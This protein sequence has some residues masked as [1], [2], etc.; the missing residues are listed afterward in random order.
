MAIK[1]PACFSL[2]W[3]SFAL[4]E[5]EYKLPKGCNYYPDHKKSYSGYICDMHYVVDVFSPMK[6]LQC[7]IHHTDIQQRQDIFFDHAQ[8][9]FIPAV[10]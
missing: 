5:R 10:L 9:K 1:L 2:L 8:S 6:G 4:Y 3:L 7:K